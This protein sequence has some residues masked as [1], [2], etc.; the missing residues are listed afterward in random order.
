M[1][2]GRESLASSSREGHPV[3]SVC[4]PAALFFFRRPLVSLFV[5]PCERGNCKISVEKWA[6]SESEKTHGNILKRG[7]EGEIQPPFSVAR[8]TALCLDHARTHDNRYSGPGRRSNRILHFFRDQIGAVGSETW[9]ALSRYAPHVRMKA[10]GVLR[11]LFVF[12]PPKNLIKKHHSRD[13]RRGQGEG[14]DHTPATGPQRE[15]CLPRGVRHPGR[16]VASSHLQGAQAGVC[17][18]QHNN[19]S[20]KKKTCRFF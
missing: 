6:H 11:L 10:I 5:Q 15:I 1:R 7:K 14:A 9:R 20:A 18:K 12:Y 2:K 13:C 4:P 19:N 8:D 16:K 17:H 3:L